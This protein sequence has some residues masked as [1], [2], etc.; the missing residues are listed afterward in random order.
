MDREITLIEQAAQTLY[1]LHQPSA[2]KTQAKD[3]PA[4]S[5]RFYAACGRKAEDVLP[6]K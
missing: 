4:L 6:L 2:D 5:Q 1:G 3:I